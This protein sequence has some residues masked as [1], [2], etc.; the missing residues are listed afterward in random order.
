MK[1]GSRM[2]SQEV[3]NTVHHRKDGLK[4]AVCVDMLQKITLVRIDDNRSVRL[5]EREGASMKGDTAYKNSG[6]CWNTHFDTKNS[7]LPSLN[8]TQN[9]HRSMWI[10]KS[11][12]GNTAL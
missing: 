7:F 4:E 9:A 5:D 8:K 12:S 1:A 3:G 10:L 11:N 6:T 2:H